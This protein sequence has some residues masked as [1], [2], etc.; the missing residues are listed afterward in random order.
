MKSIKRIVLGMSLLFFTF[1]MTGC[2]EAAADV[3][4][5][6]RIDEQE[7][8]VLTWGVKADTNLFGYYNIESGEIEGFDVDIAKALTEE[9]TDGTGE[10]KFVE[11]TSTNFASP[12]PSVI[13]SVRAF[14]IST[15][16]PSI[17]PDS[18]L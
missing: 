12:V 16:K 8:P 17:S 4:I 5:S 15:S 7:T 2:G 18:I 6:E 13:S 14:A 9:M 3:D 1:I 10:A 11:V